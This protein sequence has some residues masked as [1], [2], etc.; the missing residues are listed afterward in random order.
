MEICLSNDNKTQIY[1][2]L[3]P[4]TLH[5]EVEKLNIKNLQTEFN[6]N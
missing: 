2:H 3:R 4:S 6:S 1:A 5:K